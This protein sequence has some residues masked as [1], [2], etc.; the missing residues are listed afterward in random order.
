MSF[1]IKYYNHYMA[2]H[3]CCWITALIIIPYKN[4][5]HFNYFLVLLIIYR[6]RIYSLFY[7]PYYWMAQFK[8][9]NFPLLFSLSLWYCCTE[10]SIRM[11]V[12]LLLFIFTCVVMRWWK[13]WL[14]ARYLPK[15]TLSPLL[16]AA[17]PPIRNNVRQSLLCGNIGLIQ[18]GVIISIS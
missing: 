10:H 3:L 7:S 13:L 17:I 8:T 4:P 11:E 9:L 5:T 6:K 12:W 15:T 14:S 16:Q 18:N 1:V 2:F